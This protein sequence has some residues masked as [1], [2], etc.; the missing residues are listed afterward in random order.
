MRRQRWLAPILAGGGVALLAS[1][2]TLVPQFVGNPSLPPAQGVSA[3]S[4]FTP[5]AGT[6]VPDGRDDR[7]RHSVDLV[8]ENAEQLE[9]HNEQMLS[10]PDRFDGMVIGIAFVE[11]GRTI[12]GG[13]Q[14]ANLDEADTNSSR[15]APEPSSCDRSIGQPSDDEIG[16]WLNCSDAG[17][18]AGFYVSVSEPGSAR[19][20]PE[21]RIQDLLEAYGRYQLP[22]SLADLG[23]MA[24]PEIFA[25]VAF[26]VEIKSDVIGVNVIDVK[27]ATTFEQRFPDF[28][29]SIVASA[30]SVLPGA[31]VRLTLNGE[32]GDFAAAAGSDGFC[33]FDRSSLEKP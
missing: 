4:A 1:V 16:V 13:K 11:D 12:D 9:L 2:V 10:N 17:T 27:D 21:E 24:P 20:S 7:F 19:Q 8:I 23:Y 18:L 26:D 32:C 29:N 22:E 28:A 14:L 6:L 25:D 30:L 33:S 15:A 31:T 5:I 3:G